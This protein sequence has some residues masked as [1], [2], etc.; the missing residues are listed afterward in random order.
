MIGGSKTASTSFD[1]SAYYK[2]CTLCNVPFHCTLE[3]VKLCKSIECDLNKL[4]V[5]VW[6]RI[7]NE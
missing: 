4:L 3:D 6:Y 5:D 1:N 2:T 7:L